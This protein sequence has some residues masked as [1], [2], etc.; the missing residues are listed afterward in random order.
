MILTDKQKRMWIKR[1]WQVMSGK[2]LTK[3]L[4]RYWGLEKPA[5]EKIDDPE[6]IFLLAEKIFEK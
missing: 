5:G 4:K 3:A 2:T 6:K 1:H